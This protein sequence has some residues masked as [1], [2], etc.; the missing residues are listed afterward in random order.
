MYYKYIYAQR[1]DESG[2][3]VWGQ[4]AA[5]CD[6]DTLAYILPD[7][8]DWA[9]KPDTSGGAFVGWN[10][11]RSQTDF[12]NIYIQHIDKNGDLKWAK[13]GI[14]VSPVNYGS[15]REYP[16]ICYLPA[17]DELAVF[18]SELK[19][20]P[21]GWFF[22]LAGQK[23]NMGG[24][25]LWSDTGKVFCQSGGDTI[26]TIISTLNGSGSDVVVFFQKKLVKIIG[27]DTTIS[28]ENY[29]MRIDKEGTLMWDQEQ[30]ILSGAVSEKYGQVVAS[31]GD[32][33]VMAWQDN[34][35]SPP[36]IPYGGIYAQNISLNGKLG[37]LGIKPLAAGSQSGWIFPNPS[38]GHSML[39]LIKSLTGNVRI[40]VFSS[41][42]RSVLRCPVFSAQGQKSFAIHGSHLS[43][44]V[45]LVRITSGQ[46][47]TDIRWIIVH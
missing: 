14:P 29:A 27:T 28:I 3:P 9:I 39:H 31:G 5:I 7:F 25:I 35:N 43:P 24:A 6:L 13:N 16:Y 12:N 20:L 2:L 21:Q 37:P 47:S 41:D 40:D 42:G 10:D 17:S 33:F 18:W 45:Y 23:F 1:Y 30:P 22:E 46:N 15:D 26:Y 34:R 8:P 44:G 38:A 11:G 4:N 32:Q 19:Q 36:A